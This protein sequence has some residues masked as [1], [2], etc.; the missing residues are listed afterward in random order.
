MEIE[1]EADMLSQQ[2]DQLFPLLYVLLEPLL[3]TLCF[4]Q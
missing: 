1:E 3:Q 4:G 2:Q